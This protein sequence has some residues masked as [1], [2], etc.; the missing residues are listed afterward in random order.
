MLK[1]IHNVENIK[2]SFHFLKKHLLGQ[3]VIM[4]IVISL[5]STMVIAIRKEKKK[6]ENL[7]VK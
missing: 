4:T 7:N 3:E 1:T 5:N 2:L 6:K